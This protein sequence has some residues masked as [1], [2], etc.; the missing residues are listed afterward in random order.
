[1]AEF[2][3]PETGVLPEVRYEHT[4]VN[5][6]TCA[7]ELYRNDGNKPLIDLANSRVRLGRVLDCGC[8]AGDNAR[9]L[10]G[11]GWKVTGI[12]ISSRERDAASQYC[13]AV[14]IADLE[15]GLP[16]EVGVDFDLIVFSHV[17]E[18]LVHPENALRDARL[19]LA[20]EGVLAVALPNIAFFKMRWQL[21]RGR[22]D[23]ADSGIMD[24]THV[25]FYTFKTGAELLRRNHFEIIDAEVQAIFPMW[26]L[27]KI[28]PR[29]L[30]AAQ[31]RLAGRWLPGLFGV[32]LFYIGRPCRL[33]L[34][35]V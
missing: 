23:Y 10:Q 21:L 6:R 7:N 14:H 27:Q 17:L 29:S 5:V 15:A 26:H 16:A 4:G 31:S 33:D 13:H 9:L 11:L 28:L 3:S 32:Q 2:T 1:M 25:K 12:T 8:G 34:H 20:P 22:F 24:S 30:M 19:R 18:H 35:Q